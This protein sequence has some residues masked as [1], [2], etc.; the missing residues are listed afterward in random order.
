MSYLA[1]REIKLLLRSKSAIIDPYFDYFQGPTCYYCHIGNDFLVPKDTLKVLDPMVRYNKKDFFNS[2][3]TEKEFI[4]RPQTY[5]LVE[6]FEFFGINNNHTIRI[7]NSSSLARCG[8]GHLALGMI[9]PGCGIQKP[10]KITLE[11]FNSSPFPIKLIP[12]NIVGNKIIYGTEIFKIAIL[13]IN[14]SVKRSYGDWDQGIFKKDQTATS[15]KM[16][17]R[18][19][20]K[21]FPIGDK[22]KY[23]KN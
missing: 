14:K 20:K 1:D 15:S 22:Y 4:L 13:K 2:I 18:Y 17:L 11:L 7:F 16:H 21:I 6:S 12:T 3:S 23:E 8:I 9:N 5:I 10:I 19:K